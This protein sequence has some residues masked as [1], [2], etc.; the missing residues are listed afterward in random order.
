L[1]NATEPSSPFR[2]W[3]NNPLIVFIAGKD[4]IT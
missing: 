1:S 4:R 3:V 2:P